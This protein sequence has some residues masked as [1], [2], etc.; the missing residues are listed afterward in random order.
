MQGRV[1]GTHDKSLDLSRW[2]GL[3]I[4]TR[5]EFYKWSMENGY[6]AL[7]ESWKESGYSHAMAPSVDRV[8]PKQGYIIGNMEWVTKGENCRRSRK[9]YGDKVIGESALKYRLI[10]EIF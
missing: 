1:R 6:P 3:P 5:E 7:W 10:I 8:D 2:K 4:I 9:R